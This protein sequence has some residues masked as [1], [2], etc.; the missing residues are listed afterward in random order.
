M[1]IE[2]DS[3][4][5]EISQL[6]ERENH[7]E[8]SIQQLLN[9]YEGDFLE[10]EEYPWAFQIQ[11]RLKQSVLHLLETYITKTNEINPLLKLNCL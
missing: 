9:C 8:W 7:D 11:L 2:I 6:L 5:A 3:D 1:N 4:Y 10:D